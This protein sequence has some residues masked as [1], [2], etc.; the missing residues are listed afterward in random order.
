MSPETITAE[1]M[2]L[3]WLLRLPAHVDPVGAAALRL[4]ELSGDPATPAQARL[5]ELL[6]QVT[7]FAPPSPGRLRQPGHGARRH[8]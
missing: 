5:G 3:D 7:P 6:R 8:N 1:D 4:S 2:F